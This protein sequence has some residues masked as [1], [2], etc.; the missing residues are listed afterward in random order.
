MLAY[1]SISHA[2]YILVGVLA[3]A[4]SVNRAAAG[5]V[6]Y[7]LVV[8]G[9]STLGAFAVAAWLARD[10]GSDDI[11]DLNGLGRRSP[12]LGVC[13]TLLMLS[14]IGMPPLGGFVGKFAM[15]AE[16]L[17]E[18]VHG[19]VTFLWLVALGLFNSVVSAFYYVRV[20]KAM[21][22]RE[23]KHA[24][25]LAPAPASVW[26]PI[27]VSTLVVVGAGLQA[28][29][30]MDRM[31]IAAASPLMARAEHKPQLPPRSGPKAAPDEASAPDAPRTP[32]EPTPLPAASGSPK[33]P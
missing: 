33:A 19:R 7:Y 4:V 3:A 6:L 26:I 22:L 23:P 17:N 16:A 20:L 32:P 5:P 30:L 14:L 31:N 12:L 2:G 1:S 29:P 13:L 24:R 10:L 11:D 8:Y 21:F 25:S 9:F 15:F 27:V 18:N 28:T